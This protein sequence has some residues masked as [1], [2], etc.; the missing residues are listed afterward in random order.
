M[1]YITVL[2]FG[3]NVSLQ[4]TKTSKEASYSS[5]IKKDFRSGLGGVIVRS[6]ALTPWVSHIHKWDNSTI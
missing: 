3:G 2:S 6:T 1:C 5:G 4:G